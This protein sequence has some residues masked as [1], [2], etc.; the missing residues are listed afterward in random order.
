MVRKLCLMLALAAPAP[1]AAQEGGDGVTF[2]LGVGPK[3]S[4]EYFGAEDNALGVAGSFKLERLQFG[5]LS[6]GGERTGLGFGGS[7]RFVK[8]R[9]A[10][11]Y[12]ELSGLEDIDPSLELGGG[13]RFTQPGFEMFA[14][15]RYGVIGHESLVGELGGDV[16]YRPTSQITLSAGPRVLWGSDDY[17]Q[18]YFGVTDAESGASGLDAF[19]AGGGILSQGI[20]AEA[21]YDFNDT[22]GVTGKIRYDQLRDAA[23]DSPITQSEDQLTG[24]LLVTRKITLG[25]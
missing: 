6:V 3:S 25:F 21:T 2:R 16:I 17:A 5:D 20:E 13:L 4:P 23:A 11:D 8:E 19:E 7:L 15:L 10:D 14:N 22:W 9:S 12:S 24:S 1:L 18:T